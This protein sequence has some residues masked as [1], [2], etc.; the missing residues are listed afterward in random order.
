[1]TKPVNPVAEKRMTEMRTGMLLHTPFFAS[2]L[3]DILDHKV[4]KFP[5]IETA[6]TNGK[7]IWFDEDYVAKLDLPE[8]VFLCC[9][10]VAHC[11]WDHMNRGRRWMDLGLDGQPFRPDVYNMAADYVINSMLTKSGIGRMPKGGLL[12]AKYDGNM[13]VEDVYRDLMKNQ[14]PKPKQ[15]QGQ[16]NDKDGDGQAPEGSN[17]VPSREGGIMDTHVYEPAKISE[18]ELTR[19][20]ATAVHHAKAMGKLPSALERWVEQM[21]KPQVN[22]AER[23][24]RL[25]QR[26]LGRQTKTWST[27]HR[28]RLVTQKIYYPSYTGFGA[29][30]IVCVTDTSGSMGSKEFDASWAEFSDIIM[31]CRPKRVW[32]MACDAEVHNVHELPSYS[33]IY[34]SRPEMKGGGGTSFV[35]AFEKVEEMGIRPVVLIYFTDGYGTFPA[36]PPP[37]PVIWVMTSDVAPPFGEAVK[38]EVAD[39]D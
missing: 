20:V 29:G 33:D 39:Y 34:Q 24:R 38:V 7:V 1:M 10:E 32:L 6:G 8:V 15:G 36:E 17:G 19:A 21:F 25:I 27:P 16:G 2:L 30:E 37:Y 26:T 12:S 14:Q 35:P 23:L 28:R 4:G 31:N 13:L 5:A 3:F 9:H 11:M 22:W 18:A